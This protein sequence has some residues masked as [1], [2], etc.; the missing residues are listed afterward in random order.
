MLQ[1]LNLIDITKKDESE[2]K[3]SKSDK[4][5]T[6]QR[7]ERVDTIA[8]YNIMKKVEDEST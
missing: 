6:F 7:K 4:A 5:F 2:N 8:K 1:D 3:T